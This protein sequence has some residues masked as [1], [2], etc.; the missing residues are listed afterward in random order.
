[1]TGVEIENVEEHK[2]LGIT[3]QSNVKWNR[4]IENISARVNKWIDILRLL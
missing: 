4:H 2:H 3:L 1:M